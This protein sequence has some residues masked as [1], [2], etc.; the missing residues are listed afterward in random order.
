M[1]GNVVGVFCCLDWWFE[2]VYFKIGL[3]V[4]FGDFLVVCWIDCCVVECE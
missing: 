2:C 3:S 1:V 4:E